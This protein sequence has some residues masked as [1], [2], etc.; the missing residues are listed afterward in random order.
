MF[1]LYISDRDMVDLKHSRHRRRRRHSDSD[2]EV[3]Q[4]DI[5]LASSH[6]SDEDDES[7]RWGP[8]RP[9]PKSLSKLQFQVLI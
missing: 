4:G 5:E 2:S 1:L 8:R 6:S 3:S 7:L 9:E